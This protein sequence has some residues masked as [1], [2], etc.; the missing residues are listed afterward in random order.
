MAFEVFDYRA[1]WWVGQWPTHLPS[2]LP[3]L[4]GGAHG[5]G[6]TAAAVGDGCSAADGCYTACLPEQNTGNEY[7]S[8]KG[9][10]SDAFAFS[11]IRELLVTKGVIILERRGDNP[12]ESSRKIAEWS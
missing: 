8:N 10:C 9:R 12:K 6:D 4:F 7:F 2:A 3:A 1:G 5:A 11:N